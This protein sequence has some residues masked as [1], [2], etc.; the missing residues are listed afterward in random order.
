MLQFNLLGNSIQ[1]TVL[2]GKGGY[3][4]N[5]VVHESCTAYYNYSQAD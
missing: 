4:E 1:V 5:R 2:S 3:D